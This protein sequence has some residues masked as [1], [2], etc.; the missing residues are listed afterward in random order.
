MRAAAEAEWDV[1]YCEVDL[2]A[3]RLSW[4]SLSSLTASIVPSRG[5]ETHDGS[6]ITFL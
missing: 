2:S 3:L 5:I 1:T 6:D 4:C